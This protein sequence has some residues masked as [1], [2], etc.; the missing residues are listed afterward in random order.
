MYFDEA[1]LLKGAGLYCT[2]GPVGRLLVHTTP[3]LW[4]S[5]FYFILRDASCEMRVDRFLRFRFTMSLKSD[6]SQ[7]PLDAQ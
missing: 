7:A 5:F 2:S 6:E 4:S 3:L 1:G